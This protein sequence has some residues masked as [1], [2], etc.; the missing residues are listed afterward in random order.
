MIVAAVVVSSPTSL[1]FMENKKLQTAFFIYEYFPS[2]IFLE[3]YKTYKSIQ[4]FRVTITPKT[5]DSFL[6]GNTFI[7]VPYSNLDD[8]GHYTNKRASTITEYFYSDEKMS[9]AP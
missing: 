1:I 8:I 9:R 7:Y 5:L 2:N 4:L 6:M 3:K